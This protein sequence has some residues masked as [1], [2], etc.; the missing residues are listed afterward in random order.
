MFSLNWRCSKEV[1]GLTRLKTRV[2]KKTITNSLSKLA[3]LFPFGFGPVKLAL[4]GLQFGTAINQLLFN[5]LK[6]YLCFNLLV[7]NKI[8]VNHQIV[9]FSKNRPF[10]I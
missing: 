7:S 8:T 6:H 1:N 10:Y 9:A 4:A 3:V 2:T 5:L